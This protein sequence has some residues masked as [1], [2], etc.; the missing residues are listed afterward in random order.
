V[1]GA[2]PSVLRAATASTLAV[3]LGSSAPIAVSGFTQTFTATVTGSSSAVMTWFVDGVAS[4]SSAAGTLSGSGTT[5]TYTPPATAG[6]HTVSATATRAGAVASGSLAVTV[7]LPFQ[8]SLSPGSAS[9]GFGQALALTSAETGAYSVTHV[10]A[11]DGIVAG[12]ATVGT[13]TGS[14]DNFVYTAPAAAGS[15]TVTATSS[16]FEGTRSAACVV[17]VTSPVVVSLPVPVSTRVNLGGSLLFTAAVTGSSNTA[18]TWKVDGIASGNASVGAITAPGT[19]NSVIFTAPAVAGTHTVTATSVADPSRSASTTITVASATVQ[20][21]NPALVVDVKSAPYQAQGDGVTDDTAAIQAAVDAV[22]GTGGEVTVPAGTY[23]I[24]PVASYGNSGIVLGSNMTLKLATG[25]VLQA[26]STAT[27]DYAVVQVNGVQ[28]VNITGGSIIGNLGNNTITDTAETGMGIQVKASQ[29]VVVEAVAVSDCWADGVYVAQAAQDVTICNVVSNHN[30]RN[31]MSIVGA[32]EVVVRGCTFEHST[33]A[34][35]NGA[36]LNG[37]GVDAEPNPGEVIDTVLFSHCT[38]ANNYAVGLGTS[39][40]TA[41]TGVSVTSNLFAVGNTVSG[42]GNRGI[43]VSN[44]SGAVVANNLCS[45]NAK[46]GIL[47]QTHANNAICTGNTVT[48]TTGAPGNGIDV[49]TCSGCSLLDNT[50]TGN[51]GYGLVTDGS[52]GMTISANSQSGD[53]I[54]P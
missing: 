2:G 45:N 30:R 8:I 21:A 19:G 48:G 46:Y 12:N 10:W 6:H 4:G 3:S 9:V 18:V 34:L 43:N 29:H 32:R 17:T 39:V 52:T 26:L 27:S 38:F 22:A 15:H 33:G 53:G 51:G 31:G 13:L 37:T 47:F 50:C 14:R 54:A 24:N 5:V 41:N 7:Q 44:F 36:M 20:V 23:L 11:V 35:E 1:G 25:A 40:P 28:N 16:N 49:D 42:N